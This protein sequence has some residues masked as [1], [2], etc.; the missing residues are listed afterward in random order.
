MNLDDRKFKILEAVIRNYLQ[1]G[2]PVGS[3]TISKD[4]DMALSSATIRN[5]MAD[6]EE[7]GYIIQPHTS[8][9]R[10]PTD[11][12]YRLYVESI[13][14][15]KEQKENEIHSRDE[16]IRKREKELARIKEEYASKMDRVEEVM[17]AVARTLA[18]DTNYTT[19]ISST[20][21][22]GHKIKFVQL[23][24]VENNKLLVVIVMEGN[25]IRNKVFMINK[26]VSD[27]SLLKLNMMLNTTVT[28][29]SLDQ[30]EDHFDRIERENGSQ[31]LLRE[32]LDIIFETIRNADDVQ[33]VTGGTTNIFKYPELCVSEI[34]RDLITALED[35]KGLTSLISPVSPDD[36]SIRF[37][38]GE[39]TPV[40]SMKD[41]SVVTATYELSDG[42]SGTIGIIGPKRM[43]YEMVVETLNNIRMRLDDLF[44]KT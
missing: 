7:M 15:Q 8:A 3:R 41:C 28:G 35:K 2:E 25:I 16:I 29:L 32:V 20:V 13:L 30:L 21:S 1:T 43:D 17:Q 14:A 39:E 40:K 19:M 34:A 11:K 6:L 27:E 33:I 31:P 5:E 22:R 44:K 42:V 4:S 23:S 12:G 37:Y 10:I 18:N 38:I 36:G 9:G 26:T 24:R